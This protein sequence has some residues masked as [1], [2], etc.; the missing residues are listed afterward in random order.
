MTGTSEYLKQNN[1]DFWGSSVTQPLKLGG[2]QSV[3]IG[4]VAGKTSAAT[5]ARPWA[6]A[7]VV[8]IDTSVSNYSSF[9]AQTLNL[10]DKI[11]FIREYS[12]LRFSWGFE[13]STG[14]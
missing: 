11:H 5:T 12:A 7:C 10:S 13:P 1:V 4:G 6:V 8:Y 3:T 9:W 2:N 14:G